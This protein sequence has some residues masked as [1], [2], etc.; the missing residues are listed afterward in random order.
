MTFTASQ[1]N[2]FAQEIFCK[3][4]LCTRY[5]GDAQRSC[6]LM[7][8]HIKQDLKLPE[9]TES[10]N[11]SG[12]AKGFLRGAPAAFQSTL[13]QN[14]ATARAGRW[15]GPNWGSQLGSW[16]SQKLPGQLCLGLF[17]HQEG[18]SSETW[19]ISHSGGP[20]AQGLTEVYY[21]ELNK[22]KPCK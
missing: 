18:N 6:P 12:N 7:S 5:H 10:L 15:T 1:S 2:S 9:D 17:V 19:E 22:N 16:L 14:K 11:D 21:W 20:L 4:W 8:H 3:N 13:T